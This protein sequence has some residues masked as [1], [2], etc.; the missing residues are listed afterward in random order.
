MRKHVNRNRPTGSYAKCI[1]NGNTGLPTFSQSAGVPESVGDR[2]LYP[3]EYL[4]TILEI[5][6]HTLARRVRPL[7]NDLFVPDRL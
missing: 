5:W 2:T 1:L 7:D 3:C 4:Q 6:E